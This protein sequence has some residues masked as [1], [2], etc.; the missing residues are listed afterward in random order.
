MGVL[1]ITKKYEGRAVVI[2]YDFKT[3]RGKIT[4]RQ[5]NMPNHVPFEIEIEDCPSLEILFLVFGKLV[6]KET[7]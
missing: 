6:K 5:S 4:D 3:M 7:A 2:E 1:I